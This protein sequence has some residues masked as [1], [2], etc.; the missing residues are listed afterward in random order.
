M[1]TKP[2]VVISRLLATASSC[3]AI[4]PIGTKIA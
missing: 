3:L 1:A 2:S 4:I